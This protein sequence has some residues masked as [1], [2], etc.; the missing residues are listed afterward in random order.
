MEKATRENLA[1]V[2]EKA[3]QI[4]FHGY[5]EGEESNLGPV[6]RF[7]PKWTLRE[8]D[9][10]WCAAFV[11]YCCLEAGFEI[12]I[13]PDE[14]KTCHLAGCIAWEEFAQGDP[15]IVY[16]KGGKGFVP[17]AGD[18]VLY[19]RVFENREHDHMGI[20]LQNSRNTIIAAEG[21]L[22][23]ISGIIERP[24]DA[25][26]R[27]YIRIPDGYKY[28]RMFM[29]YQTE[30]LILHF[31]TEGDLSEV[32]RTWPADHHPLS[33]AEARAAIASMRGNYGRNTRGRICHLCLAVCGKDRP[34]TI[35]G[36][37]GLDGSRNPAEPE[38]F[39][40]LDEPYRGKGFGTQCVKK[41]LRIAARDYAL[42]GVHGGC[43]KENIA[44]ARAMEKGGMVRYGTE[45]NGD[46]LFRFCANNESG[47]EGDACE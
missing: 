4:P 2:A 35:M 42:S 28:R 7:F 11:Y 41:L 26:I 36:W 29:D 18:I 15:R 22:D 23:N 21:N 37:C 46:P 20:V 13:R 12:P 16:H 40:L 25:H 34:G 9:R 47:Q 19:D 30:S 17:E 32:A 1:K 39:I 43:A 31:V 38:I 27:G 14:C 5:M 24:K 44:S 45:E 6:I 33:D 8:A 10:L 3:A